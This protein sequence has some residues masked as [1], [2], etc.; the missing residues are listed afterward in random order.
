MT[1]EQIAH[2]ADEEFALTSKPTQP[3]RAAKPKEEIPVIHRFDEPF[4]DIGRKRW[5]N[6]CG[7]DSP[8][9]VFVDSWPGEE[10][11]RTNRPLADRVG[12]CLQWLLKLADINP[13]RCYYTYA[14]KFPF[15]AGKKPSATDR[16]L[17]ETMLREELA[18]LNPK[19]V[20]AFG[21]DAWAA[22]AD[23][24]KHPFICCRGEPVAQMKVPPSPEAKALLIGAPDLVRRWLF[25]TFNL[26][27]VIN[28]SH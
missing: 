6:G 10:I 18:R 22:V 3:K 14:V 16:H 1:V 7:S 21:A 19:V 20:V 13:G 11:K 15:A 26:P 24:R 17:C 12:K 5:Y 2:A 4:R 9:I 8:D 28:R 27:Q 23:A 25:P